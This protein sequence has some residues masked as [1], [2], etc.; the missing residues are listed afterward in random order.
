MR[1]IMTATEARTFHHMSIAN[2][3]QVKSALR[4][5]C[6]PYQDVFTFN[7]W[8][9]QGFSVRRG[10]HGIRIAT[11]SVHAMEDKQTGEMR[12]VR[13]PWTSYVFCRCQVEAGR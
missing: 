8:R 4:C 7:R 5:A 12:Q 1:Q 10:E 2:M 13:R 11:I 3:V 6:D 9:A